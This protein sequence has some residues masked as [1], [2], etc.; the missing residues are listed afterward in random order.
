MASHENPPAPVAV[1]YFVGATFVAALPMI[2][3]P[4]LPWPARVGTLALALAL[5]AAGGWQLRRE[6][7]ASG[8]R[9]DQPPQEQP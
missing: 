6:T 3:F 1:W 9:A 2:M 5:I 7:R 4:D 8:R